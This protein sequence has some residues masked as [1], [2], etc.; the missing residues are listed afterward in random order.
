MNAANRWKQWTL[1]LLCLLG[2]QAHMAVAFCL[3]TGC[4]SVAEDASGS[5][6]CRGPELDRGCC[7]GGLDAL[8]DA[9]ADQYPE[10][11]QPC[12]EC[13]DCFLELGED[14]AELSLVQFELGPVGSSSG[15][16][17]LLGDVV[18]TPAPTRVCRDVPDGFRYG[19][20]PLRL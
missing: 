12:G 14:A 18:R 13:E 17:T 9:D 15:A 11:S 20:V 19:R 4:G 2:L 10:G 1:T 8:P 3:C 6:C 7:L 16:R 5:D